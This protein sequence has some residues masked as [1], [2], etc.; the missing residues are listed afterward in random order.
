MK[1]SLKDVKNGL[2]R[3]GMRSVQG[4]CGGGSE[5]GKCCWPGTN[6]CSICSPG[7]ICSPGSVYRICILA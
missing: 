5:H 4:G 1:I 6:N 2:K 3:D 7:Y